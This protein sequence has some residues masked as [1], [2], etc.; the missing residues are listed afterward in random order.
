MTSRRGWCGV[1]LALGL[2]THFGAG[3]AEHP[4]DLLLAEARG[5]ARQGEPTLAVNLC[6][7]AIRNRPELPQAYA[8]RAFLHE[9]SGRIAAAEW[10]CDRWCTRLPSSP[11]AFDSRG[12]LRFKLGLIEESLRDFDRAIALDPARGP[13]HWQRGISCW[14]AGEYAAGKR[15]FEG[16]QE[17]DDSDVENAVWRFLCMAKGDSFA[18]ARKSILKIGPDRRVPMRQVYDLFA[19]KLEP[20]AVTA[21]VPADD[22]SGR[23]YAHLYLGLYFEV[24]GDLPS[25]RKHLTAA[26]AAP[27]AHYMGDVA[28][29]HV[30][31]RGWDE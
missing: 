25:A 15:Q 27:I 1:F 4:Y 2:F 3:A 16:Y 30:R 9:Q 14:Y 24:S 11:Q 19:G 8:L 10:D 31:L 23:F 20:A 29:I 6:T 26:A 18:A 5:Q 28:R 22:A 7:E 21:A 13:G 17:V 12:M